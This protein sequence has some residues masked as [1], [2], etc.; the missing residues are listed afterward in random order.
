MSKVIR[1]RKLSCDGEEVILQDRSEVDGYPT[2]TILSYA[3]L[4]PHSAVPTEYHNI[5]FDWKAYPHGYD[6]QSYHVA[7]DY[8]TRI[9][10]NI[11]EGRGLWIFSPEPGSGKS[12][13]AAIILQHAESHHEGLTSMWTTCQEMGEHDRELQDS[14]FWERFLTA[15]LVVIDEVEEPFGRF[16]FTSPLR[17][18]KR[19]DSGKS[20]IFA[21]SVLP[22]EAFSNNAKL[23]SRINSKVHIIR[24]PAEDLRQ[25][26]QGG[27]NNA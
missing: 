2:D 20:V 3:I 14:S 22:Q 9:S 16:A 21:G 27:K 13:L 12:L 17:L 24:L 15:S 23:I 4:S 10:E 18:R 8:C 1:E 5:R 19:L 7:A 11:C 25:K 26:H 6:L